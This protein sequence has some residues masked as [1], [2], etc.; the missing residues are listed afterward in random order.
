MGSSL[1]GWKYSETRITT[2]PRGIAT[3]PMRV[4]MRH[5][6]R[7][8]KQRLLVR[9]SSSPLREGQTR[10]LYASG[11]GGHTPTD[12]FRNLLGELTGL[13]GRGNGVSENRQLRKLGFREKPFSAAG[14]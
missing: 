12:R 13:D 6:L 5:P 9:P 8:A 4:V 2:M 7:L 1:E 10:L 3:A 14:E 11:G